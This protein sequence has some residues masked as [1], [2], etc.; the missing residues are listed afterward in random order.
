V[1]RTTSRTCGND[2]SQSDCR[3][4]TADI[5]NCPRAPIC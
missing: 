5:S 3:S 2:Q 1:A 4:W